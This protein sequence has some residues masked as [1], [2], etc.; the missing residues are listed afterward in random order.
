[1]IFASF[2]GAACGSLYSYVWQKGVLKVEGLWIE[3]INLLPKVNINKYIWWKT[4]I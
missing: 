3:T 2:L 4:Y 1:M